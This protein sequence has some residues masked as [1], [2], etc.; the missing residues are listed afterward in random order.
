MADAELREALR[1]PDRLEALREAGIR[2][3]VPEEA[4]DRITRLAKHALDV[5]VSLINLLEGDR[6]VYKSCLGLPE[7]LETRR[8]SPL[9]HSYCKYVVAS[10]EPLVADDARDHPLLRDSP[11]VEELDAIAYLGVPLV[12]EDGFVLGTHCVI[13]HEPRSWTDRDLALVRDLAAAAETEIDLRRSRARLQEL[14]DDVEAEIHRKYRAIFDTTPSAV[15]VA[16]TDDG[17]FVDANEAFGELLGHRPEDVVGSTADELGVWA[18]PEERDRIIEK[19]RE[20]GKVKDEEVEFRDVHG[21][22]IDVAFSGS[23]LELG[24]E[25]YLVGGARDVTDR[26]AMEE[27]L[28]HRALHDP[29]TDLPNRT[30]LSDRVEQGLARARRHGAALGL[31]MLDVDRFKRINDQLGHTAG[32]RVLREIARRL[33]GAVRDEDTVGRWGGDEFVAVLPDVEDVL[34]IGDVQERIRETVGRPPVEA[35]GESL[36]IEVGIGAVL[37]SDAGHR[38]AVQTRDPEELIRL[39]EIALHEAKDRSPTGFKLYDPE[40]DMEGIGQIRLEEELRSALAHDRIVPHFQPLVRLE[41][42]AVVGLEALARWEHPDRGLVAP[43][44]FVP[45][46]E[47]VGLIG[48]V[49]EAVYREG[50]RQA[51]RWVP[52]DADEGGIRLSFNLSGQQFDD[53]ELGDELDRWREEAGMPAGRVILEVTET[54]V[55]RNPI[56]IHGLQQRGY[57]IYVDDFGTGYST[58]TYLRDLEPDGLKID[59]TFVQGVVGS[60]SNAALVETMLTL[61]R[62]LGLDV[63]AEGIETEEQ[64][65]TLE[66]LGCELGQGYLFSRPVPAREVDDLLRDAGG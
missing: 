33:R 28:R 24:G 40:E 11:A 56:E 36:T 30:L 44:E 4:F 1:D 59:M 42:G 45:L 49:G 3:P 34:T 17:R 60:P 66:S 58:F 43:S 35:G 13:D 29:L 52:A 31:L 26:K 50:C 48:D 12:T 25:R 62:R 21:E 65:R 14:R 61:G 64:R 55:M 37:Y 57:R 38:L 39:G 20:T 6:Q 16:T 5:P 32:D 19:I 54:S 15:A 18:R 51:A 2:D 22:T 10:G 53:P 9:D 46:A 63:V 7:G 8:E 41:D 47:E 23:L 27:R